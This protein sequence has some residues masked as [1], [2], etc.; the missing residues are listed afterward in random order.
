M[1]S[2]KTGGAAA[3]GLTGNGSVGGNCTVL[4]GFIP[5]ALSFSDGAVSCVVPS[6]LL[7]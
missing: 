4:T 2:N 6:C 7:G 1:L 5:W 3:R